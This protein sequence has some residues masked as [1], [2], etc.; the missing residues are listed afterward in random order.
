MLETAQ[1]SSVQDLYKLIRQYRKDWIE[2]L[3]QWDQDQAGYGSAPKRLDSDCYIDSAEAG[4]TTK[5]TAD[6]LCRRHVTPISFSQARDTFAD[7]LG[8]KLRSI[9]AE[10]KDVLLDGAQKEELEDV[11][12]SIRALE[13][14]ETVEPSR[15][16]P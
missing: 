6:A 9:A 13:L 4:H 16:G 10:S 12:N 14:A 2:Y 1:D 5:K 3:Q 15:R 7:L 11:L 8:H